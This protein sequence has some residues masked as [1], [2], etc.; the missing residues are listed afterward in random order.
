[1]DDRKARCLVV[2][3]DRKSKE[4]RQAGRRIIRQAGAGAKV[5][6]AT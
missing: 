6:K 4:G 2:A 1:M 3:W 5:E